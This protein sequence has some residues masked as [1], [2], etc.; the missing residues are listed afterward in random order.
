MITFLE[1]HTP[2]QDQLHM[3]SMRTLYRVFLL[4]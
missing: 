2:T 4:K 1:P 3:R